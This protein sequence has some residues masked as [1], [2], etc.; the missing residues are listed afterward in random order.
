MSVQTRLVRLRIA[1]AW[2]LVTL[3][4]FSLLIFTM[5]SPIRIRPSLP[6]AP[7]LRTLRTVQPLMAFSNA[8]TVMPKQPTCQSPLHRCPNST[9]T[10]TDTAT[11]LAG[12]YLWPPLLFVPTREGDG[13][14]PHPKSRALVKVRVRDWDLDCCPETMKTLRDNSK[15]RRNNKRS[16]PH[17]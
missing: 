16:V 5:R 14:Y 13:R 8:S 7:D 6:N 10:S 1:R 2:E 15:R 17:V 3:R 11:Y 4:R 12:R 9:S